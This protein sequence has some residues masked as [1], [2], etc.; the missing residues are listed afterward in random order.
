MYTIGEFSKI[1]G[2]T[3]KTLR[4]YHDKG[5]LVPAYVNDRTGYRHYD[6]RQIDKARM[7][8]QLRGLEFTLEQI[9]DMLATCDDQADILDFLERQRALLDEKMHQYRGALVSLKKLIQ[10]EQEA[11]M[12]MQNSTCQVEEKT[13]PPLLI[14]GVRM[15]AAYKDCSQGFKKLGKTFWRQIA[16]PGFMLH[17][18]NEYKDIADYE[19][20]FP[21]KN[22]KAT[23]GVSVRELPGGRCVCLMHQGPY[24]DLGRSYAKV[25][26][27]I[28]EKGYELVMPTREV[29]LK[30]PGMIFRGNPKKYL[31]EIQMLVN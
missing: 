12:V 28:K 23:A 27:Y 15:Q 5:L 1:T 31:T 26:A 8:M 18:D 21:I 17:Y 4:F 20:C 6:S 13:L 19:V 2:L 25:T 30:G 9:A 3:I 7:I 10:T 24:E 11:R 22:G 14:A 29:Y 16:G